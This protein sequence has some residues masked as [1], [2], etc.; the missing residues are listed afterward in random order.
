M[1]DFKDEIKRLNITPEELVAK[2]AAEEAAKQAAEAARE[3]RKR[4]YVTTDFI[5]N[6]GRLTCDCDLYCQKI[7]AEIE[8]LAKAGKFEYFDGSRLIKYY[9]TG[10]FYNTSSYS[11]YKRDFD[12]YTTDLTEALNRESLGF[13]FNCQKRKFLFFTT[14]TCELSD[15]AR[16]SFKRIKDKLMEDGI[17][18]SYFWFHG[19]EEVFFN[20]PSI[21]FH[22]F[23]DEYV[24]NLVFQIEFRY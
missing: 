16:E 10:G 15:F 13:M 21:K 3:E 19:V 9:K 18:F 17:E 24:P 12:F 1:S 2:Q 22:D 4:R 14:F 23:Y 20:V 11:D 8:G 6:Y 7:K 5:H